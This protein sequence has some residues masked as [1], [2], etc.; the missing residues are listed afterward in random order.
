[1]AAVAAAS[2][3]FQEVSTLDAAPVALSRTK[4][5]LR[6]RW[7]IDHNSSSAVTDSAM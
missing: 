1:L 7:S 3:A 6:R 5:S 2:A 4:E